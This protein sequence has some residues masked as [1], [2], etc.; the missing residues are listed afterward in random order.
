MGYF[1]DVF[2][3]HDPE[4]NVILKHPEAGF[5]L[6]L[7]GWSNE[8]KCNFIYVRHCTEGKGV[9]TKDGASRTKLCHAHPCDRHTGC[10][11]K[12]VLRWG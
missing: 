5:S 10:L 1:G 6:S 8:G 12:E 2:F 3:F 4:L 9:K 11:N 7:S